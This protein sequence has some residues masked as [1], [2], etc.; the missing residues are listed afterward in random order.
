MLLED[1]NHPNE[2]KPFR[3]ARD[4]YKS[5]MD[6]E[7]IESLG[8]EPLKGILTALGGWPV[9]E[10][11]SWDG[12]NY[13]WYEQVYKFRAMGYSVDYFVD[14][15]VTTDLKNSSWRVL[16]LDQPGLGLS[17]EYLVKGLEDEDVQVCNIVEVVVSRLTS[18]PPSPLSTYSHVHIHQSGGEASPIRHLQLEI[19]N[20]HPHLLCAPYSILS[21]S[22]SLSLSLL[23]LSLSL[24]LRPL[25]TQMRQRRDKKLLADSAVSGT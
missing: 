4:V 3:M 21:L 23:S 17:R 9:L 5:C 12:A 13:I 24:P 7:R 14:F 10:G 15:S 11:E 22:L 8:T 2:P 16:D 6:K 18:F 25:H 20:V 1:P 19:A